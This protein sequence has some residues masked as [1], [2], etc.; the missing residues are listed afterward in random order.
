MLTETIVLSYFC[1]ANIQAY[2]AF[3]IQVMKLNL[4]GV[5]VTSDVVVSLECLLTSFFFLLLGFK[6]ALNN[7]PGIF[8]L[9]FLLGRY[10]I[11]HKYGAKPMLITLISVTLVKITA[12]AMQ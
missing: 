11:S 4:F 5:L 6:T 2:T 8:M 1:G 10:L 3:T 12:N 9:L 7:I